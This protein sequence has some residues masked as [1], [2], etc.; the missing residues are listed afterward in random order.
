MNW[1]KVSK[2]FC[3]KGGMIGAHFCSLASP[4][5]WSSL[6]VKPAHSRPDDL[7]PLRAV[8]EP[9]RHAAGLAASGKTRRTA[10]A[11]LGTGKNNRSN[12]VAEFMTMGRQTEMMMTRGATVGVSGAPMAS[13]RK[14]IWTES[15]E[16]MI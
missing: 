14:E 8:G 5:R 2:L 16:S 12:R 6:A 11:A 13:L 10:S 3:Y 9:T 7:N 4:D 15:L 1:P